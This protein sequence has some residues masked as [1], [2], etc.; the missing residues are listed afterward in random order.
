MTCRGLFGYSPRRVGDTDIASNAGLLDQ[1]L[2]FAWVQQNIHLFGGDPSSITLMGESAGANSIMLHLT[3]FG[4]AAGNLGPLP[5]QRAILQSPAWRPTS[6]AAFYERLFDQVLQT[7]NATSIDDLRAMDTATLQALN[8]NIINGSPYEAFGFGTNIDGDYVP[9]APSVLLSQGKFNSRIQIM[10][11]H[12]T[13]EGLLFTDDT[14]NDQ[15]AFEANLAGLLPGATSDQV[16]QLA[17]QIY[18]EDFSGALP[19]S[20]Q[21]ERMSVAL[22]D[23]VVES[24]AFALNTA[25]QN[26]TF[27]YTFGNFPGF[28]AQDL[29][30]TFFLGTGSGQID[31]L[32]NIP[33][34]ETVA[35]IMQNAFI[36]F[37]MTGNPN[38]GALGLP[39][40]PLYGS[41]NLVLFI[42]NSV[43]APMKDS[44]SVGAGRQAFWNLALYNQT[45]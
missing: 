42:N 30:Y 5:F 17:T 12:N 20:T 27:S 31:G 7:A 38:N 23:G 21:T 24:N 39:D 40:I 11:G 22:R 13:N 6:D 45:V 29:E 10:V 26:N 15:T 32:S 18:P 1:R 28:H 4:G 3:S 16:T 25:F 8:E 36:Q 2:A 43:V 9:A 34:N 35:G 14:V 44:A 33:V 37:A 19:Y 41:D